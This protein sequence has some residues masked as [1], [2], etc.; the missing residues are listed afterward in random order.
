MNVTDILHITAGVV[1][2]LSL[3]L[4][5][6]YSPL[7]YLMNVIVAVNLIIDGVLNICLL[8]YVLKKFGVRCDKVT[9]TTH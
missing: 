4:A 1:I 7:Y 2:L 5:Q 8:G 6:V 3:Y 9:C